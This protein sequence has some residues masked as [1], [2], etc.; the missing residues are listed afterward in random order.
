M[1]FKKDSF[2][3]QPPHYTEQQPRKL[4]ILSSPPWKTQTSQKTDDVFIIAHHT[5]ASYE[6]CSCFSNTVSNVT[7]PCT[8]ILPA[9]VERD[10]TQ[11]SNAARICL[12]DDLVQAKRYYS[13]HM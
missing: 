5:V 11:L 7:S 3:I 13:Y 10:G 9:D 8:R 6:W 4:R 1:F 12:E 2:V